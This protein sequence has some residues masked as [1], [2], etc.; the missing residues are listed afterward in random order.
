M[1]NTMKSEIKNHLQNQLIPFWKALRDNQYGGYYGYMGVDGQTDKKAVKGCILNS[2]ITWFFSK[3]YLLLQEESLLDEAKHGVEFLKNCCYDETFGGVYWSLTYDGKPEDDT[4]HTYNQAFAIYALSSYYEASKEEDSIQIAEKLYDIIEEKCKD[5][6]GYLEAFTRDFKP[7]SNEKLSENGVMA[8]R[9]MNTLLHIFEAYT[10]FYKVTKKEEVAKRLKWMLDIMAEKIYNP[11]LQRQEVFFD[12][13]YHSLI[14]L[15]SYGHD[16]ETAWLLDRGLEVLADEEY[17]KK[18]RPIIKTL[19]KKIYDTAF[20]GHS[21]S[22]ECERGVVD[23]DR[24]WW[25]QAE[26][27]VGFLNGWQKEGKKEYYE[28]AE[29]I[30]QYIKANIIQEDLGGEWCWLISKDGKVYEEKPLVD[31][32]KCP[33]HNGRMCIETIKRLGDEIVSV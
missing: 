31:P 11:V 13:D 23:T 12:L 22:N 20:D 10:E 25:V 29:Q 5:E 28:A 16:I 19:T 33:Y 21:V 9:T 1:G 15:H 32:W 18:I 17:E 4:K 6:D 27:I 30:W 2:R 26:S 8:S 24:V 7:A 3:A 14:D